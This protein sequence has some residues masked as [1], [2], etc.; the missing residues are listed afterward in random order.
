MV[1]N[2]DVF[3]FL[4]FPVVFALFWLARTKQ[5]RYLLLTAAGYVFYG[6][7]N[8]KYCFLLLFS[9]FVSFFAARAITATA[10]RRR[11]RAWLVASITVDL[12]I[13]GVF[14]Y[15]N[16]IAGS[17]HELVPSI[18]PVIVNVALPIGISFYTFHTISYIVDVYVG[19]VRATNNVFEYLTYVSFF[20]Q[21]VAG[22][23]AR[24]RQVESDLE[25]ID[26]RPSDEL[27][28]RGL[29]FFAVGMIKKVIVADSIA[30]YV[31]PMLAAFDSLT[32]VGAWLVALGYTLQLYYDF[33]GYSDMAVGLGC[34]FGI[35]LPQNFN[36]PYRALGFRDFWRRWHI[37]L[38]T[39][40][41]DY[42]Y[43]PLGGN[44]RGPGRTY[45]NLM[46]TMLL[47]GLWHGANWTFVVWGG[48]H[49]ALLIADRKLEPLLTRMPTVLYRALTFALV[50]VGWVFFRAPTL[51]LAFA[52]LGEMVGI[53]AAGLGASLITSGI[54]VLV[55]TG[56]IA[57]NVVPETWD[58]RF[59]Y[60]RRF[61]PAVAV[62]LFVCYLF[63][64]G[65]DTVFLYYQ[66]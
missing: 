20:P 36:A 32:V 39:W 1:F 51:D 30:G 34:L 45:L 12:T 44:R 47:G 24:F 58:V 10:D 15:A 56:L 40:L 16:F 53:G 22:P 4:F 29:G 7:W 55:V 5:Q 59:P 9:S 26:R 65:S 64:N 33:S 27:M 25:Q 46:I 54:G 38:S 52:W 2:S 63:V 13:L 21:L 8:W 6:Y 3:L 35:R 31:V 18:A 61:A 19:R 57:I 43:L 49:G 17:L 50:V 62:A 66:F 11:Q 28:A 48:Y 60:G 37:S 41:R 42:L 23:I 14:K